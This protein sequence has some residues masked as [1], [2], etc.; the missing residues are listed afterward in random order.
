MTEEGFLKEH[1]LK[2][3]KLEVAIFL[4]HNHKTNE[5]HHKMI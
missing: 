5:K 4:K 1:N 2:Y 3:D